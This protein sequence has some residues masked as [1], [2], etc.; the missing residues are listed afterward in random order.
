MLSDTNV[1]GEG[2]YEVEK[3]A[4]RGERVAVCKRKLFFHLNE[5]FRVRLRL[6]ITTLTG[7]GVGTKGGM[8]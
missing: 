8:G 3:H 7:L 4:E 2:G 5:F 6:S 1:E